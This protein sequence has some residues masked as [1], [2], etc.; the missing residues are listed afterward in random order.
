[1]REYVAD[2]D[3]RR[4]DA[5]D[6]T[7]TW[8]FPSAN[9]S[10]CESQDA[11]CSSCN[12][13]NSQFCTGS[14]GCVCLPFCEGQLWHVLAD[15]QL[16]Y[17]TAADEDAQQ[18]SCTLNTNVTTSASES[19]VH[20]QT[21]APVPPRKQTLA[22]EDR[23]TWYTNQTLCGLPRTC[24]D[25]L[26]LPLENGASCTITPSGYCASMSRYDATNDYRSNTSTGSL[27]YF[28][29]DNTTYCESNDAACTQL[30]SNRSALFGI[31]QNG[32]VCI[33]ACE[34]AS[35]KQGV[36]N[37]LCVARDA[38]STTQGDNSVSLA[39]SLRAV[40][41]VLMVAIIAG[42]LGAVLASCRARTSRDARKKRRDEPR[43]PSLALT[44]WRALHE[45]LIESETQTPEHT[46][47]IIKDLIVVPSGG[48][49]TSTDIDFEEDEP[50][51]QIVLTQIQTTTQHSYVLARLKLA[52]VVVGS[53]MFDFKPVQRNCSHRIR[54][55]CNNLSVYVPQQDYRL[56]ATSRDYFPSIN[57]TYCAATDEVCNAC[58]G[59][60]AEFCAGTDGCVCVA[61]CETAHWELIALT[62]LPHAMSF[63]GETS[64]CDLPSGFAS[65]PPAKTP[66]PTTPKKQVLAVED[67]CTWYTNQTLCG[68]PRT[69]YDC[70]NTPLDNGQSCTITPSG[71]CASFSKYDFT[72]DYRL[73]MSSDAAHYFPS[74]NT[75]Y[76]EPSDAVCTECR[77][78]AF[79]QSANGSVNPSEFCVGTGGCVC[80]GFCESPSWKQ[81][82]VESLCDYQETTT[83]DTLSLDRPLDTIAW[84]VVVVLSIPTTLLVLW[85]IRALERVRRRRSEA[86]RG[87]S[88]VLTNWKALREELIEHE[89]CRHSV[90]ARERRISAPLVY[91]RPSESSLS[92]A[93]ID[94]D[95]DDDEVD[96]NEPREALILSSD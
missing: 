80:V 13:A 76:C 69:C 24:Y 15:V 68:L 64:A 6:F 83:T 96:K 1:M 90:E 88:L 33:S 22:V 2:Q 35:W 84:I 27:H 47:R 81:I 41:V 63:Q 95:D 31:G 70:L 11:A 91:L 38:S 21:P 51:A 85:S 74:T 12:V 5:K 36:N 37:L 30:S 75:T 16:A 52:P 92:V 40:V 48:D 78:T 61:M 66:A 23:C 62:Q 43:G 10:Y 20:T 29:S 14:N 56:N 54:G 19:I 25:C 72:Q 58:L 55:L 44:E 93:A 42:S 8:Y 77:K 3:Y 46:G 86:S 18:S 60:V 7:T 57:S 49:S 32:C 82:V 39:I 34:A 71:Y 9:T 45:E 67:R 17:A 59:T 65:E 28:P 94:V 73:N 89:Q 4:S 79:K 50:R 26:N 53:A 87:L